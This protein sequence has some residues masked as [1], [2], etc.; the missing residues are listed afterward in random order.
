MSDIL[1]F[2]DEILW[3]IFRNLSIWDLKNLTQVCVRFKK[4]ISSNPVWLNLITNPMILFFLDVLGFEKTIK[5]GEYLAYKIFKKINNYYDLFLLNRIFGFCIKLDFF[6]DLDLDDLKKINKTLIGSGIQKFAG[7]VLFNKTK[8]LKFGRDYTKIFCV[9]F[10]QYQYKI[11]IN[12]ENHVE[13]KFRDYFVSGILL[14]GMIFPSVFNDGKIRKII[15]VETYNNFT[16][17]RSTKNLRIGNFTGTCFNLDS[18]LSEEFLTFYIKILNSR[19]NLNLQA[20]KLKGVIF[21]LWKYIFE[22]YPLVKQLH[23][24][25]IIYS[26]FYPYFYQNWYKNKPEYLGA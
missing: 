20:R 23:K 17:Y 26:D 12:P 13:K 24:R 14:P 5:S 1:N 18:K 2:P 6:L 21:N 16:E 11:F 19:L 9:D 15:S 25:V 8:I 3:E 22:E 7:K 4:I 10:S